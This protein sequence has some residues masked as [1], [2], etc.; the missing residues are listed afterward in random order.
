MA[1]SLPHPK[2]E[3]P[4]SVNGFWHCVM[5]Y[6]VGCAVAVRHIQSISRLSIEQWW[7]QHFYHVLKM[8]V[9]RTSMIF[10]LASWKLHG[11]CG[12]VTP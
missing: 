8:T 6:P 9:N 11:L 12:E 1:W 4:G 7:L 10:G 5:K 2:N 3:R